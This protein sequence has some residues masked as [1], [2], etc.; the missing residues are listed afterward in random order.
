MKRNWD[1]IREILTMLEE[2]EG[3]VVLRDFP[4]ER[5]AEISYNVEIMIEAGLV[6]G[7]ISKAIG[8]GIKDF[9]LSRLT[10]DGHDFLDTIR[11]DSVWQKT[12]KSFLESGL[13]MSFEL[14][15]SVA[16]DIATTFIKTAIGN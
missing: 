2:R 4:S 10:W 7:Q 15:K 14:V 9:V 3:P 11:S 16:T 12:K 13:S 6:V 8:P 1:T 5:S